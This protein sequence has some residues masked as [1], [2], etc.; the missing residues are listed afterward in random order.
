MTFVIKSNAGTV[1][2]VLIADVGIKIPQAG[3]TET[4]TQPTDLTRAA[5]S[6][7][8]RAL[9]VDD[10]FGAGSSTLILNNGLGN[11]EQGLAVAFLSNVDLA[12]DAGALDNFAATRNPIITDDETK[13]YSIGSLWMH[14]PDRELWTCID[15]ATGAATWRFMTVDPS[16]TASSKEAPRTHFF[17]TLLDYPSA[18]GHADGEIQYTRLFLIA[19]MIIDQMMTFIAGGGTGTRFVRL[20][21]YDQTDPQDP[22]LGPD[23]RIAQTDSEDTL[24]D[25][26][27]FKN[28]DLTDAVTGGSGLATTW[29]V[30]VSGFYWLAVIQ[31]SSVIDFAVT[32]V[33]YRVDFLPRREE[34]VGTGTTLPASVGAV[35]NPT[36]AVALVAVLEQ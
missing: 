31:D 6:E 21:L 4:L 27:T 36:S 22:T 17:G 1:A 5:A 18:G 30:P 10:A 14:A 15:A 7:D 19:G 16:V 33:A 13:G 32:A 28:M 12:G 20:G 34:D 23:A 35:T 25:N 9:I 29:T 3:G 26:D 11:I 8:L 24:G 2:D